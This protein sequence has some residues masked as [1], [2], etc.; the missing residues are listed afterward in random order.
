[1]SGAKG[2]GG[3]S[4]SLLGFVAILMSVYATAMAWLL[5]TAPA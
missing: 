5:K 4:V 2:K 3:A 1:L